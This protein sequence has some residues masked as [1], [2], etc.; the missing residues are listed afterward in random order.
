MIE[1]V[2]ERGSIT[3][4]DEEKFKWALVNY[5][6]VQRGLAEKRK[7]RNDEAYDARDVLAF[8]IYS[9]RLVDWIVNIINQAFSLES[10]IL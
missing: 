4:V 1:N 10:A 3:Q 5:C 9:H 2:E 6:L 8:T 7:H